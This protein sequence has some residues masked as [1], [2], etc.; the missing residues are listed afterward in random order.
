VCSH[1]GVCARYCPHE[2]L[3]VQEVEDYQHKKENYVGETE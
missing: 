1:C 3:S 2:C